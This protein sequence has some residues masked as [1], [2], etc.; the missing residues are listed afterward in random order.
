[1]KAKNLIPVYEGAEALEQVGV[2]EADKFKILKKHEIG[3]LRSFCQIMQN[4]GAAYPDFDGYYVGYT[5]AQIGKEF[6]L[7]RFGHDV[8]VNIELKTEL[9]GLS[10]QQKTAKILKQ[11]R[12]NYFYLNFLEIPLRIFT[13]VESDGFYEYDDE[14]CT[15]APIDA[16]KVA[17]CLM[18]QEVDRSFDPDKRFVPSDYL[19]SPFNSPK[20]FMQDQYFLTKGQEDVKRRI[21]AQ[22]ASEPSKFFTISA[23]AGTGKTLLM[24]DIAKQIMTDGKKP[25]II[26]CGKLNPG[27]EKLNI[28]YGWNIKSIVSVDTASIDTM[29]ENCSIVFVDEAQRIRGRQLELIIQTAVQNGL[30]VMFSYDTKQYLKAGENR[31]I[32]E[33]L[34][35]QHPEIPVLK[36]KLTNKIRTN[37]DMASFILNLFKVGSAPPRDYSC[38]SIDYVENYPELRKYIRFLNK[39]HWTSITFTSSQYTKDAFD[40]LSVVSA[41]KAHDVI[42]QEFPNVVLALDKNFN[43]HDGHLRGTNSYYSASGMLYQILTRVVNNLKIVV[44]DNP[45]L[46]LK[47]LEIQSMGTRN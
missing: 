39:N 45:E 37:P 1:M 14:T 41:R 26:H 23:D 19:I 34:S 46:Y 43:Y 7:L 27:Q 3:N 38:V 12:R 24:Y 25:L 4:C 35:E 47:L 15:A 40:E 22:S 16:Q 29:L 10:A 5:I 33:Y 18:N 6:D 20:E 32:Y 11:M 8:A 9:N 42:G 17:D 28:I 21:L 13:Y 31:D 36:H 44:C 30:P 2:P